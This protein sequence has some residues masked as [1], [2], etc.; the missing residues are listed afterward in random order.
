MTCLAVASAWQAA[1]VLSDSRWIK[2]RVPD[3]RVY[4]PERGWTDMALVDAR[5]RWATA[6]VMAAAGLVIALIGLPREPLGT[7]IAVAACATI[8]AWLARDRRLHHGRYTLICLGTLAAAVLVHEVVTLA[9]RDARPVV[10]LVASVF[11]SQLYLVAGIRKL[12]SPGFMSG[13]VV[14]DNLAYALFHGAAGNPDFPRVVGPHRL[15]DLLENKLLVG[16]C[17]VASVFTVA[18]ELA[19][20]L[21]AAG[22]L[23]R[24]LT[25]ALAVPMNLAFLV[26]SP[27]RIVT[28]VVAAFGLLVL[29]TA[30][31]LLPLFG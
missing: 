14:M 16:T 15:A 23:P 11:A 30:S 2:T 29:G 28:F 10:G 3:R 4:R 17:R 21:G 6:G 1:M 22:L 9:D 19:V 13:Q 12:T 25:L 26:I 7:L 18:A 8:L 27:K 5:Q 20:G 24:T 31:P